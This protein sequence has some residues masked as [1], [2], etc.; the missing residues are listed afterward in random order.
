[1]VKRFESPQTNRTYPFWSDHYT[2]LGEEDKGVRYEYPNY[3]G[4]GLET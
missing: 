2:L 4:E 1:M 3:Y